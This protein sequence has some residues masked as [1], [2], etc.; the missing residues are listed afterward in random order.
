MPGCSW[1]LLKR[2]PASIAQGIVDR[3]RRRASIDVLRH[4]KGYD[5]AYYSA[6]LHNFTKPQ[7]NEV[8]RRLSTG[9]RLPQLLRGPSVGR[10]SCHTH[11]D[12]FPRFQFDDEEGKERTEQEI[13]DLQAHHRPTYQQ[14]DYVG[15]SPT[16]AFSGEVGEHAS[17]ISGSF[18]GTREYPA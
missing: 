8:L 13:S 18:V 17:C 7:Y 11:V 12:D 9:S 16:S 5:D 3:F 14:R 15:R 1:K 10:K 2:R 4:A 6:L